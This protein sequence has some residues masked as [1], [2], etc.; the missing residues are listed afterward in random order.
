MQEHKNVKDYPSTVKTY[1]CYA[2]P[3]PFS[4][5]KEYHE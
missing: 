4:H 5:S 3:A 1:V 2:E